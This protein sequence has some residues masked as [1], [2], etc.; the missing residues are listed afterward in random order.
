MFTPFPITMAEMNV[1]FH[2]CPP[3]TEFLVVLLDGTIT[4]VLSILHAANDPDACLH[5][6]DGHNLII[7]R[8]VPD[9]HECPSPLDC[10]SSTRC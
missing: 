4:P 9:S 8:L 6:L 3:D 2:A 1:M 7:R 5:R 10:P